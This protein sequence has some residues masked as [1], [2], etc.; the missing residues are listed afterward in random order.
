MA[1]RRLGGPPSDLLPDVL[2]EGST[3]LTIVFVSM[4]ARQPEGRDEE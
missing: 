2:A 4:S 3:D 1:R